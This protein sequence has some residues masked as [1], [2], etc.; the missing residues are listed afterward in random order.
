MYNGTVTVKNIMK[1]HKKNFKNTLPYHPTSPFLGI[2]TKK[3][4]S[5]SCIPV[6]LHPCVHCSIT[7]NSQGTEGTE[8][9]SDRKIHEYNILYTHRK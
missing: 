3:L 6:F 4:K 9:H 5:T 7:G 2:H 1:F 8:V